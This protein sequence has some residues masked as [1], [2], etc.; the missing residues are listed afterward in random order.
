V[1]FLQVAT[2]TLLAALFLY[3][4][5]ARAADWFAAIAAI[6]SAWA[7]FL[8]WRTSERG[9]ASA[10]Q[11]LD[12]ARTSAEATLRSAEA[13]A[14][15][16]KLQA[17]LE[18]REHKRYMLALEPRLEYR[19]TTEWSDSSGR[20]DVVFVADLRG[21]ED[22][23]LHSAKWRAW[24]APLPGGQPAP[25]AHGRFEECSGGPW[26][27]RKPKRLNLGTIL[28]KAFAVRST[29]PYRPD[30]PTAV[31]IEILMRIQFHEDAPE[32]DRALYLICRREGESWYLGFFDKTKV[33][34]AL[35]ETS[36]Q[37]FGR[38]AEPHEDG[39][40]NLIGVLGGK[41]YGII[42]DAEDSRRPDAAQ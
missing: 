22:A 1:W 16:V 40:S 14:D 17:L 19:C 26:Q 18:A 30:V 39:L 32:F 4:T 27:R 25:V 37:Q 3:F 5:S 2:G 35:L 28:D 15:A 42:Q 20:N 33:V 11:S 10:E 8:A 7:A 6:A 23:C 21:P 31:C 41:G 13:A 34:D 24:A 9:A 29:R 36:F 12:A 38:M